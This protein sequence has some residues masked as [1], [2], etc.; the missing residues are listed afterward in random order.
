MKCLKEKQSFAF[1][2][3]GFPVS[4]WD[5]EIMSFFFNLNLQETMTVMTVK[6]DPSFCQSQQLNQDIN[7][8]FNG[9]ANCMHCCADWKF[10]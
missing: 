3:V 1:S 7:H 8:N 2:T 10:D 4:R 6:N 9:Q 5:C